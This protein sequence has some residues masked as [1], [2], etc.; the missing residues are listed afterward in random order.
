MG[1]VIAGL[2]VLVIVGGFVL[3]LVTNSRK[4]NDLQ[5]AHDPGADQNPLGIF[6]TDPDTPAGD[7]SQLSDAPTEAPGDASERFPR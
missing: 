2:L 5:D 1:Y 6:A 7:T 4:K 3:F